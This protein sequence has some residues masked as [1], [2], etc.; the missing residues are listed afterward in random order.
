[1]ELTAEGDRAVLS[2]IDDGPGIPAEDLPRL[3]SELPRLPWAATFSGW[4]STA[5]R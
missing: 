2:V 1:M 5:S 3:F 4:A